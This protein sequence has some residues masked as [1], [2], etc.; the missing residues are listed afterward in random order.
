[1][2]I[3]RG[4][5]SLHS[6]PVEDAVGFGFAF[7]KKQ[8]QGFFNR[9]AKTVSG[10]LI[11]IY[12]SCVHFFS[13]SSTKK[14]T[15]IDFVAEVILNPEFEIK[16]T[17]VGLQRSLS[18]R[19]PSIQVTGEDAAFQVAVVDNDA[20]L[21]QQANTL[22][23]KMAKNEEFKAI[24]LKDYRIT[25]PAGVTATDILD[26]IL[27]RL[28]VK[29]QEAGNSALFGQVANFYR[30]VVGDEQRAKDC[31]IMQQHFAAPAA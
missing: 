15:N 30:E 12:S 29:A 18:R 1:M 24:L 25:N 5:S 13:G 19:T 28:K 2:A 11:G 14:L 16:G 3:K 27:P 9:F 10:L 4:R 8:T 31:T 23:H 20:K 6:S 26:V 22:S 21:Q 17:T 7:S